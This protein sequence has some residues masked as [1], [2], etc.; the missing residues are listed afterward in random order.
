MAEPVVTVKNGA[1]KGKIAKDYRG[2]TYYSFKGIPYAKPPVGSLRF[3]APVPH[4]DWKGIRSAAEHGSASSSKDFLSYKLG[5]SEDCLFVNVY[6]PNASFTIHVGSGNADLY[7]PEYLITEDVV[8]VTI[9][10]RLGLLGALFVINI[11]FHLYFLGFLCFDDPSLEVPGNAGLKDQVMALKWIQENIAHFGGDPDNVTIFGNSA[12]AA[13]VCLLMLSPLATGLFHKA[14]VQSGTAIASW[15]KGKRTLSA[16]K[17][18]LNMDTTEKEMFKM[19]QEMSLDEIMQLQFK[20]PEVKHCRYRDCTVYASFDRPFG[21]V[22]ESPALNSSFLAEDPLKILAS[23]N[24]N[25]VPIIT[26]Y[27]SREGIFTNFFNKV[28][29]CPNHGD[30]IVTD[31]EEEIPNTFDIRRGS[32]FSKE[33]AR[34]IKAYYFGNEESSETSRNQF[35]LLQGDHLF[36][37]PLYFS[38]R[39]LL[40]FSSKSI[41]LYR[42]SAVTE[43]N[44]LKKLTGVTHPGNTIAFL[45]NEIHLIFI[46]GACHADE[47]GYLFTNNTTTPLAP[48]SIELKTVRRVIK[49]WAN[50]ARTGNPN[51]SELNSLINVLWKPVAKD[52]FHFLD[53]GENLT[54]GVNPDEDRVEFWDELSSACFTL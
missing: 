39:Y 32:T 38:L 43:L 11:N 42:L 25:H 29:E 35:Y 20:I 8:L 22:I 48:F 46:V 10:Y 1:L 16:L 17:I 51:P 53:I 40:D 47:L 30:P 50:F 54:V 3:K 52:Q 37:W 4:D 33:F 19:L 14:I 21:P 26:G 9:N 24:Y 13:S 31:F 7:G 18:A 15:A 34:K 27:T 49:L 44:L 45:I 41:Y 36:V 12:G 23:G 28:F 5:G 2:A 6:T